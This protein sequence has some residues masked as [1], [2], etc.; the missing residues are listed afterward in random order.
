MRLLKLLVSQSRT[1][2]KRLAIMAAVAGGA[3]AGVLAVI[4]SAAEHIKDRDV[5]SMSIVLFALVIMA[6]LYSQRYVLVVTADEVERIVHRRRQQLIE[7]LS[8]CELQEVEHVGRGR[9]YSAISNDTQ[10]ISQSANSLVLGVQAVI[11]IVCTSL[12]LATLSMTSLLV[13]GGF[14]TVA[15]YL[16]VKK[17]Q[18]V[19]HILHRAAREENILHDL[20]NGLL[21]GFKEVKLWSRRA[22]D[23]LAD[24]V[25]VSERTA[26]YRTEAARALA[27]NFIFAQVSFF[28]LLGTL[29]FLLPVLSESY[30]DTIMK[31]MTVV[32]FLIG[33]IS[34]IIAAVPQVAIAN[35][36][37]ENLDELERVLSAHQ[38]ANGR[39]GKDGGDRG[40]SD[41]MPRPARALPHFAALELRRAFFT[42][43]ADGSGFAVGPVDVA[44]RAGETVLVTGGNGSG[45]STLIKLL[46]ALYAPVSGEL[47]VNGVPVVPDTAQAF[48]D[49]FCAVFSDFH[50]FRKLYGLPDPDPTAAAQLLQRMEIADKVSIEDRQFSTV[51]LSSGQRK[52]LA[53]IVAMLEDKPI[54]ILDEWA[55]DQ[56]PHFRRKFYEELL[57]ELKAAGKTII[58][59][60]HDD[61][62]FHIADR[63]LHMEEGR[64]T[65]LDTANETPGASHDD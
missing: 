58:A 25:T 38:D 43:Q 36:A 6:Y 14:L 27:I 48:R 9:I 33:P 13:A 50:L 52:R 4:N 57:P 60:T 46:T 7:Q 23:V 29:V 10:T 28:L 24:V 26:Q 3:N 55:A 11:L 65:E 8:A 63:R 21:D 49:R 22:G 19:N 15:S 45:K 40:S 42:H 31:S 34:G 41:A 62:Y 5:Q 16:Y 30:S 17:M 20:V 47:L 12:Y 2:L 37:A 54:M 35:T 61:R 51:D 64:L 39:N 59:V 1:S 18:A 44:I 53:L 56:D 32:M